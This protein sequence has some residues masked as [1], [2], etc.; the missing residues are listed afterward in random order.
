MPVQGEVRILGPLELGGVDGAML[1]GGRRQRVVLAMLALNANR[2]TAVEQLVDAVW[3]IRPPATARAQIQICI[4]GLRRFLANGGCPAQIST[5][6]PGY[7]LEIDNDHLDSRRFSALIDVARQHEQAGEFTQALTALK[8]A[9]KLWRGPVLGDISSDLV[10][11]ASGG[12]SERRVTA[13]IA[14]LRIELT[15]GRTA[16]IV[17]DLRALVEDHPLREEVYGHLM[18]ALYR[19]GRQAEAL[20]TY[21]RARTVLIEEVGL[22]PADE[23]RD[24]EQ[25]ILRRDENLHLRATPHSGDAAGVG[26]DGGRFVVPSQ[27]PGGIGDLTGRE[28]YVDEITN[29]LLPKRGQHP[30]SGGVVA[31]SGR[32]GMG[33]SCL[34]VHAAHM[35]RG[36]F[37]DGQLYADMTDERSG[38]PDKVL[39]RFL[40][41]LGINASGVP[42]DV[43]ER[44]EL[45]RSILATRRVVIVLD[46]VSSE[47][48]VIPLLPGTST[49]AVIVSSKARLSV[50]S[51]AHF[52]ELAELD[53]AQ[54]T[55]FLVGLLGQERVAAEPD[56]VS[57]LIKQCEGLPLALRIAAARLSAKPHWTINRFVRRLADEERM[58]DEL[59]HGALEVRSGIALTYR[60]L[61]EQGQR[62]LRL[63]ALV[64]VNE[65]TT[66]AAAALL[67][68]DSSTAEDA[69]EELVDAHVL[70]VAE[71]VAPASTVYRFHELV[72]V[73]AR[74]VV[75]S[76]E[77]AEVRDGAVDRWLGA[78]LARVE[79]VHRTEYGGDYTILHGRAPRWRSPDSF[80]AELAGLD[81]EMLAS[82]RSALVGAI[83]QAA[84]AGRDELCWDLMLSS[85]TLFETKGYFDDW[86]ES[87]LTVR[88]VVE[89]AGNRRGRAAVHYALGALLLARKNS[90]DAGL[91]LSAA[92]DL[93]DRVGDKHGRGLVL[94]NLA[95]LD[96]LRGK[97]RDMLA[98]YDEALA[99]L[100][101]VG[102]RMGEAHVLCNVA[103]YWLTEGDDERA[104]RLLD[105]ALV[106][107]V[108]AGCRR[109][110]AQALCALA[111]LAMRT[112]DHAEAAD[113]LRRALRIV[114]DRK[115]LTGEAHVMYGISV[116]R[117]MEGR[118]DH[119]EVA[120][121]HA[122]G[123]AR[124]VGEKQVEAQAL[125][126]LA[127]LMLSRDDLTGARTFCAEALALC[128]ALNIGTWKAR[129][130][131]LSAEINTASGRFGQAYAE[132]ASALAALGE[133][134]GNEAERV[135]SRA[136]QTLAALC[137]DDTA[138]GKAPAPVMPTYQCMS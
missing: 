80:E 4:S 137:V 65:F 34:A 87:A 25:A 12:L 73:Y 127:E 130:L 92:L 98:K 35:V 55:R 135:R 33:K 22:E 57:E 41:A 103:K 115:D 23:L 81:L 7:K 102:D 99:I 116:V 26:R 71:S 42:E 85:I 53:V 49:C 16:E 36:S 67:D 113:S 122:L 110:E 86:R 61:S 82:E 112:G 131:V 5:R 10:Q 79:H 56:A 31:I 106:I 107:S 46:G 119:A 11:R 1:P 125:Y 117:H 66:W 48:Q 50:P 45:Y 121:R 123:R 18:L 37:P 91:E 58:L 111:E 2:V 88:D 17:P 52:I 51:G 59:A 136:R 27:L 72:R 114:R 21:R 124:E 93:F 64:D 39:D 126:R 24:L 38:L 54:S 89:R 109:G 132:A 70:G 19:S 95:Y 138:G 104:R 3:D 6:P 134:T 63:L 29:A 14:Q 118:P 101:S 28:R 105:E 74:E 40:R 120:L 83:R 8:T 32:G 77:A 97:S 76:R 9:L 68:T 43:D 129:S 20:E 78:W 13:E 44:I 133:H 60:S 84:K 90:V 94:R 62:L 69:L 128:A 30:G 75:M 15:L 47:G 96:R 100:R 108:E